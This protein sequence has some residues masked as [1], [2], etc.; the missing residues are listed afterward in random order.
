MSRSSA[1]VKTRILAGLS[2]PIAKILFAIAIIRLRKLH[3]KGVIGAYP[4][5]YVRLAKY[6][7]IGMLESVLRGEL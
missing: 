4:L 1:D 7:W 5:V 2:I 6:L 3:R